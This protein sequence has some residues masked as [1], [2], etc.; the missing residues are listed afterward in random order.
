MNKLKY[1]VTSSITDQGNIQL[2]TAT[3]DPISGLMKELSTEVMNLKDEAI[4]A[5]L[6]KLGWIAPQ[7]V[8]E[9]TETPETDQTASYEGNWDTKALRMT[10]HARRLE[11]ERD[12]YLKHREEGKANGQRVALELHTLQDALRTMHEAKGRHNT[13][14]AMQKLI[15]LLPPE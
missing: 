13:M 1:T 7:D 6:A 4:R 9:S 3:N 12:K 15:A 8:D 2:V 11:R 10:R 5:A 14:I